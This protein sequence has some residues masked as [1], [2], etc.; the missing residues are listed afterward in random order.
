MILAQWLTR[1]KYK[2]L[3]LFRFFTLPVVVAQGL[4]PASNGHLA[5]ARQTASCYATVPWGAFAK[6]PS[7]R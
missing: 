5:A 7:P 3:Q 2:M 1:V 4:V 6:P